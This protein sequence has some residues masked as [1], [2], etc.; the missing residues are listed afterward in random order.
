MRFFRKVIFW[1]H[2]TSGI[3]AGIFIFIMCVTGALLAFESNILEYA[4]RQMRVVEV[5]AENAIRLPVSEIIAVVQTEKPNA[6]LSN[7]TLR[8]D[9]SAAAIVA[10]GRGEQVFVNP[11]TGAITGEGAKGLARIFSH[12]SKTLTAGSRSPTAASGRGKPS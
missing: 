3:L 9:E 1:L 5:P 2:L 12:Q 10:V 8:N 6:K 11:Y 7:I 4:E